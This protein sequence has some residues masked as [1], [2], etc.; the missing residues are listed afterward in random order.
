MSRP[1]SPVLH[2]DR[3]FRYV[4]ATE[5]LAEPVTRVLSD[6]FAREPMGMALGISARDL[7]PLVARFIPECTTNGL[8]VVAVPVDAPTTVA[9]V[10]IC[11]DYKSPLPDRIVEDF[12]W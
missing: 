4:V 8:S 5:Q 6:S 10:F 7:R 9:G 3:T 12:P 1:R 2:E 11:R